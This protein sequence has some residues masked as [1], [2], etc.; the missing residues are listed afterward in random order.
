M[1]SKKVNL[2]ISAERPKERVFKVLLRDMDLVVWV[3]VLTVST[4]EADTQVQ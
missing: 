3:K 4:T 1:Y 2:L